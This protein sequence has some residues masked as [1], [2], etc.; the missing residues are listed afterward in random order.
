MQWSAPPMKEVRW[1]LEILHLTTIGLSVIMSGRFVPRHDSNEWRHAM[2]IGILIADDHGVLRAGLRALLNA[3]KDLN[4]VGEAAD[5]QEAFRTARELRPDVVLVDLS[6]PGLNGIEVTRQLKESHPD[7]AVLILTVHEDESLLQ[8]AIRVG[9]SGYIIKRAVE[10]ELINAIQAVSR[11]E[12][13]VHPAMTR[14]LMKDLAPRAVA[15]TESLEVADAPRDRSAALHRSRSY[16]PADRGCPVSERAHCGEPQGEPDEQVEPEQSC[17]IGAL[18]HGTRTAGTGT[19]LKQGTSFRQCCA[20]HWCRNRE[21]IRWHRDGFSPCG[22]FVAGGSPRC[23][24]ACMP[25]LCTAVRM[26]GSATEDVSCACARP[27]SGVRTYFL[28]ARCA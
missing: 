17:R 22:D 12:M 24:L 1:R 7:M 21:L 2:S 11:G 5:G 3:E 23:R 6:M 10:S 14:A 16:Q 8:E 19:T 26:T 20:R 28:A 15:D 25:E 9:A 18:C 4:V 27:A 13:Y